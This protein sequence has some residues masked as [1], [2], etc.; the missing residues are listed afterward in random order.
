MK[1]T[2]WGQEEKAKR[3]EVVKGTKSDGSFLDWKWIQTQSDD[4]NIAHY[5]SYCYIGKDGT[6]SPTI[7]A[8]SMNIPE[9]LINLSEFIF[10][11]LHRKQSPLFPLQLLEAIP[12]D[13]NIANVQKS[14]MYRILM[15]E[16]HGNIT[17]CYWRQ[18]CIDA[19]KQ[20]AALFESEGSDRDSTKNASLAAEEMASNCAWSVKVSRYNRY[21]AKSTPWYNSSD[22]KFMLEHT[23]EKNMKSTMRTARTENRWSARCAALRSNESVGNSIYV[24]KPGKI[25]SDDYVYAKL[26]HI[27]WLRDMLIEELQK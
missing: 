27:W 20:C 6:D 9:R 18:D 21:H 12:T 23:I 17:R 10:A 8:H 5:R 24:G 25:N 19:I 15:D 16:K 22:K 1:Q 3:L 26:E 13:K 2:T 11:R 4:F 14:F 7:V